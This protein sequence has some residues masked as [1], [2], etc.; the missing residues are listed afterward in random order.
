MGPPVSISRAIY[1]SRG[2]IRPVG[3]GRLMAPRR[4]TYL[5]KPLRKIRGHPRRV[6]G[7]QRWPPPPWSSPPPPPWSP[8]P[9][10]SLPP[11]RSSRPSL[12]PLLREL[13]FAEI[14]EPLWPFGPFVAARAM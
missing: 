9:W 2:V 8:R 10:S 11:P 4:A 7:A 5:P 12:P 13:S 6:T 14:D 3:L 1:V